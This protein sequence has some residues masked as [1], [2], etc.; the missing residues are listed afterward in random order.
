MRTLTGSTLAETLVMMIVAG[1]VFLSGMD[2]L[3]LFTRL[4]TQRTAA[5]VENGRAAEGYYRLENLIADADSIC[6]E[7]GGLVL[8]RSGQQGLLAIRDS[9]LLYV[10]ADYRDT[11]FR[12]AENLSRFKGE[13]GQPDTVSVGVRM[14]KTELTIRV[15]ARPGREENYRMELNRIEEGYGYD[16]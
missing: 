12:T 1:V 3:T 10:A 15:A 11:L 6:D 9:I 4:Q 14:G 13:S 7:A 16:E 2:G 8:F 5:L